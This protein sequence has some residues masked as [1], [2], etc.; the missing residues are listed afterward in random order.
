MC[1]HEKI[2]ACICL[3]L[4]IG[5]V[6][7]KVAKE[8]GEETEPHCG[9]QQVLGA[10]ALAPS[11]T[12]VD[13]WVGTLEL[14][15]V[16]VS[17]SSS[18]TTHLHF[19]YYPYHKVMHNPMLIPQLRSAHVEPQSMHSPV[20]CTVPFPTGALLHPCS[21]HSPVFK[22]S[23]PLLCWPPLLMQPRVTVGMLSLIASY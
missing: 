11:L 9:A 6:G 21:M 17:I 22:Q 2:H 7:T 1:M 13:V 16:L 8:R 23:L 14:C 5:F 20:S 18:N 19:H 15:P 12:L 10:A 3:I 4:I